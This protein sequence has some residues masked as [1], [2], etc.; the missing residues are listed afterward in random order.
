MVKEKRKSQEESCL[1]V[2]GL[3]LFRTEHSDHTRLK[4][5]KYLLDSDQIKSKAPHGKTEGS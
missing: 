2:F 5:K 3:L 1:E 4:A